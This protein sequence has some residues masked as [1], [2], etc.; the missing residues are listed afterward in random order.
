MPKF[1]LQAMDK[2]RYVFETVKAAGWKN[3]LRDGD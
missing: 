2:A 3:P 1:H